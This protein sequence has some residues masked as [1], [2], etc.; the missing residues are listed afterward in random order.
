MAQIEKKKKAEEQKKTKKKTL[1]NTYN[2]QYFS[3]GEQDFTTPLFLF[4]NLNM[5]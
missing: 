4:V 5:I 1:C 3:L 2:P